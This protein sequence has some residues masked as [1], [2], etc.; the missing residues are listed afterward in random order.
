MPNNL[1]AETGVADVRRQLAA[2][3][4]ELAAR[5]AERDELAAELRARTTNLDEEYAQQAATAEVLR[6]IKDSPM[7]LGSVFQ[8]IANSSARLCNGLNSSVYR[9]D[10]ELIH[11]VAEDQFSARAVEITKA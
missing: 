5:T 1:P 7:D 2:C 10:G 11:F 9:F 8:S 4:A 3:A 6:V